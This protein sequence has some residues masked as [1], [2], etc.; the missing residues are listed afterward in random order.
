[1]KKP[2]PN[3]LPVRVILHDRCQ[4]TLFE[5]CKY[6]SDQDVLVFEVAIDGSC[7]D[8]GAICNHCHRCSMEAMF[9]NQ[10]QCR[11]NNCSSLVTSF[12]L[13]LLRNERSFCYTL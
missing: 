3:R 11:L 12:Q 9:G 6:F 4:E 13:I 5:R 1:M 7:S 8:S 10:L 2:L